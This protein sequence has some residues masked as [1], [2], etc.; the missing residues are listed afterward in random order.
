MTGRLGVVSDARLSGYGWLRLARL[1][2]RDRARFDRA[3]YLRMARQ[4]Y[5]LAAQYSRFRGGR[6]VR[7]DC[8]G[9]VKPAAGRRLLC[10]AQ[11]PC[12]RSYVNEVV[13]PEAAK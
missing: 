10:A 6:R 9:P 5:V 2:L 3:F 12:A 8:G 7:C 13:F 11:T 1:A 4:C